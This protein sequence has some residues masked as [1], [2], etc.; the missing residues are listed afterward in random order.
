MN[1]INIQIE[2]EKLHFADECIE[3]V[4]EADEV[5]LLRGQPCH[6]SPEHKNWSSW[7]LNQSTVFATNTLN[8]VDYLGESLA[9]FFGITTPKYQYEINYH[10]NILHQINNEKIADEESMKGWNTQNQECV[11][12]TEP[13]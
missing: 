8:T 1:N 4:P 7:I 13:H 11:T 10:N 9:N 2:A 6:E 5:D 3:N 12:V